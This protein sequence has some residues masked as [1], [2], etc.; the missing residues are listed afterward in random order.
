M[1]G[2]RAGLLA[3]VVGAA[4]LTAA[5]SGS[6][7][8]RGSGAGPVAT[9]AASPS[10]GSGGPPAA[11]RP[12]G[13]QKQLAYSEC[14]RSHGVPGVPTSLPGPVP[15]TPPSQ[16]NFAAAQ[17]DGPGPGSPQWQAAQHACRSLMPTPAMVPG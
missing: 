17:A 4:L 15:G 14:M 8:G 10:A 16:G 11:G 5:C 12:T 1:T 7:S 6:P 2:L 3:I 9:R 13:R